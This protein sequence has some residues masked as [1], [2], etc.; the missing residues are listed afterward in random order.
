MYHVNNVCFSVNPYPSDVEHSHE[1]PSSF[2]GQMNERLPLHHTQNI[3]SHSV[4]QIKSN[5]KAKRDIAG[6]IRSY[7]SYTY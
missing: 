4:S 3:L 2:N 1:N 5:P 6:I 7:Y